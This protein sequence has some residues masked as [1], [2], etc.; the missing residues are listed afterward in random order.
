MLKEG[1]LL[2][3]NLETVKAAKK[4]I[5]EEKEIQSDMETVRR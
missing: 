4:E 5:E 1:R 3:S 2:F